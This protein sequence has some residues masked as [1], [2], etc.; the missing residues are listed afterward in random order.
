MFLIDDG[1][2]MGANKS[3]S[4]DLRKRAVS[5]IEGGMSRNRSAK[6]FEAAI[7]TAIG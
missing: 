1:G 7:S 6:Q 2:W 4:L 5:A 3:Y